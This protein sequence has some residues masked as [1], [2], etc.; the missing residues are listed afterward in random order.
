MLA[1][2]GEHAEYGVLS[3]EH[4]YSDRCRHRLMSVVPIVSLRV[5]GG[6]SARCLLCGTTGPVRDDGETARGVLLKHGSQEQR[7]GGPQ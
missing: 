1:G 5:E 4:Y 2:M 6:Y 7:G 3:P